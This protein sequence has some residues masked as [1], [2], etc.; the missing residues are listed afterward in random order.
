MLRVANVEEIEGLM[1]QLP[2]LVQQQERHS[3]EFA[4]MA[5]AW[6]EAF[7]RVLVANRLHEAATVASLRST[8]IAAKQGQV[9]ASLTFRGGRPTRWRV[10]NAIASEA[11]RRA[12]E[13]ANTL[14]EEYKPRLREAERIAQQ[15]VAL[16]VS[17][18]LI[19]PKTAGATNTEYLGAVRRTLMMAAELTT[20]LAH[21]EGLV[22][23]HDAL[24]FLDRALAPHATA[25]TVAPALPL[26]GTTI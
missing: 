3:T 16:G 8:L 13:V 15:I 25:G 5:A 21:L 11:L 10:S 7:E 14:V 4:R 2:A 17:R 9:P 24:I 19:H 1:L 20:A 12:A 23:P 18:G 22:G 6:L 26:P